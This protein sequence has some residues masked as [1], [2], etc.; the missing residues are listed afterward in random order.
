VPIRVVVGGRSLANGVVEVSHRREKERH[1]IAPD[2]VVG[3]VLEWT[4]RG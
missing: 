2:D 4:G 3:R 1:E